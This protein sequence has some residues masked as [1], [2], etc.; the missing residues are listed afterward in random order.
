[1]KKV[2]TKFDFGANLLNIR[3]KKR[4]SQD[5]LGSI[6]GVSGAQIGK[7]ETNEN[8]PRH[9]KVWKLAEALGVTEADLRGLNIESDLTS[10]RQ[11][12]TKT[13]Q[14]NGRHP[15]PFYDTI[16][17]GGTVV[18]AD[19][20]AVREPLEMIYPGTFLNT[21]TGSIRIYGH[22][23][24]PKYPAGCIVAYKDADKD[25]IIWG[26]DYVIELQDRRLI[27]RLEKSSVKDS[28]LAVSYNKS[29]DYVYSPIDIPLH[30]IKRLYMVV[31]KVEL[32]ASI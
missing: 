14:G 16:A 8:M 2:S 21:A 26:E 12:V 20:D 3:K 1:M 31:G 7:Y 9:E 22:S 25:V 4:M 10:D 6:I 15:I 28:V 32:E 13:V 17:V 29:E 5:E 23:M 11:S 27:K 30:K 24:F 19:Q 18:L